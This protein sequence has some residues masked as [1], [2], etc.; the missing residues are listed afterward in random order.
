MV[1]LCFRGDFMPVC[2]HTG[3]DNSC[4]FGAELVPKS[5]WLMAFE[6][7]A[8]QLGSILGPWGLMVKPLIKSMQACEGSAFGGNHI[9]C[10]SVKT[11]KCRCETWGGCEMC[12][13]SRLSTPK[14]S[15]YLHMMTGDCGKHG[16]A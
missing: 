16:D 11:A 6:G 8:D 10:A 9:S 13:R 4:T 1:S 12:L 7:D 15:H 3:T 2:P 5:Q 14:H